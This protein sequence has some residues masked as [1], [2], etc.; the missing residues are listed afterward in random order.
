MAVGAN[1]RP[2]MSLNDPK[3]TSMK[4]GTEDAANAIRSSGDAGMVLVTGRG[5]S[6]VNLRETVR[7]GITGTRR[8]CPAGF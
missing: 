1:F 5:D 4:R 8:F 2:P 7:F 6:L 3:P